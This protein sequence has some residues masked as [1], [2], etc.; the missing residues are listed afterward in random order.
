MPAA[1][2]T[3]GLAE[4]VRPESLATCEK[5]SH[6]PF[7]RSTQRI[8]DGQIASRSGESWAIAV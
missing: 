3:D 8:R 2:P 1:E 5:Q 4:Q 7:D 6:G